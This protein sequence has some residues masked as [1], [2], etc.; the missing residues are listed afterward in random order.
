MRYLLA[1][2][3]CLPALAADPWTGPQIA[4]E[5]AYQAALLCAWRQTSDFHKTHMVAFYS[6]STNFTEY[7]CS[8]PHPELNPLLGRHP[9]QAAINVAC[10]VSCAGHLLVSNL[11]PSRWRTAWQG[12][13][14]G[15]EIGVVAHNAFACNVAVRF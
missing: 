4:L 3:L 6:Y 13:T 15:L 2:L 11:L 9:S 12:V 8:K 14:A 1:L 5:G 10:V 7:G